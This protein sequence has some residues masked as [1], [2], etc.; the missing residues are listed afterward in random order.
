MTGKSFILDGIVSKARVDA[1][2]PEAVSRPAVSIVQNASIDAVKP[3]STLNQKSHCNINVQ[4]DT[5]S[6]IGI[7]FQEARG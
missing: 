3:K 4:R 7:S 5:N 1:A 6:R 2:P